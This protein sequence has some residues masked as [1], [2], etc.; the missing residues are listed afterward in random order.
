VLKDQINKQRSIAKHII[1]GSIE[2]DSISEFKSMLQIL[3]DNPA[4]HSAFADLLAQ[5][6]MF[7]EAAG[8][9]NK[10]S[11]LY[12][13][14]SM[15][16]PSILSKIMEWRITKPTYKDARPYY[17]TLCQANFDDTPMRAFFTG[18]SFPELVAVTNRL[19]R[20][21]LSAGKTIKKIGDMEDHL[22]LIASGTVRD[23]ISKPSNKQAKTN[24]KEPIYLSEND[25]FGDIFPFNEEKFSQSYTE[26]VTAVE[27]G[28]I[29]KPRLIELCKK[30]PNVQRGIIDLYKDSR[31]SL[32]EKS[33]LGSRKSGRHP[34]PIQMN[35]EVF[36]DDA[37]DLSD[38]QPYT[39]DGYSRDISVGGVCVVLDA[40]Y[41]NITSIF[42]TIKNARVKLSFPGDSFTLNVWGKIVWNRRVSF[43][44]QQT[45]TVGIQFK[46]MTPKMS[47]MLVVFADMLYNNQ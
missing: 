37:S 17:T 30:Y 38:S 10:A 27:L 41:A 18:L 4:L 3:P 22:Y 9:Y 14:S 28:K 42:K 46:E 21:R 6:K 26:A 36:P 1:D 25:I 2:I 40:K 45:L 29:S 13:H 23:T 33:S 11:S 32:K 12:I 16:L 44:G 47:G 24:I 34:L 43:E 20:V 39:L 31:V 8:S 15:I 7:K 35:L 5:K 19:S